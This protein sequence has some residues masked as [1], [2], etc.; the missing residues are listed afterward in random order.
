M[1]NG[2]GGT[3]P[4]HVAVP[5]STFVFYFPGKRGSQKGLHVVG[6]GTVSFL[7]EVFR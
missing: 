1:W 3:F 4:F 7:E 5:H 6:S 2:S